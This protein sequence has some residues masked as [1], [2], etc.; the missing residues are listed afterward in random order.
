MVVLA[1]IL[2]ATGKSLAQFLGIDNPI[3]DFFAQSPGIGTTGLLL[4]WAVAHC[5]GMDGP[6]V[7]LA[8]KALETGSVE[9]I[10]ARI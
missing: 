1:A 10:S 5:D 9:P 2:Y 6:V 4:V 7:M 3:V 8:K